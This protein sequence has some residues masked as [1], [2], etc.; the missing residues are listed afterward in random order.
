MTRTPAAAAASISLGVSPISVG[1]VPN[2]YGVLIV[3]DY[4][5]LIG[6]PGLSDGHEFP[7]VAVV[8]TKG[9]GVQI[10]PALQPEYRA[11]AA[12]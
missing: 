2:K 4:P 8:I 9:A 6:C 5:L 11:N 3:E 1:R 7:T 12:C 10:E